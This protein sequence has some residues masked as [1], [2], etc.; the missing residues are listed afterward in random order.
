MLLQKINVSNKVKV[1]P[2][3]AA[4][5]ANDRLEKAIDHKIQ[6]ISIL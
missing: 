4:N 6:I 2:V 5:I 1:I 3:I